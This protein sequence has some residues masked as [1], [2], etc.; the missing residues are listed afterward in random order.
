MPFGIIPESAFG[1]AGIPNQL[2]LRIC[3]VR[4]LRLTF[5]DGAALSGVNIFNRPIAEGEGD[6]GLRFPGR[7][8]AIGIDVHY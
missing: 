6:D 2:H 4:K 5:T 1:F 7:F 8:F 3:N